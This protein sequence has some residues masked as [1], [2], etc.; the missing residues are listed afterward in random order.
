MDPEGDN[1]V[2]R[3]QGDLRAWG[4]EQAKLRQARSAALTAR[5]RLAAVQADRKAQALTTP[6]IR[7]SQ[8]SHRPVPEGALKKMVSELAAR[9]SIDPGRRNRLDGPRT[10]K[11]DLLR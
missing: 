1:P 4:I 8:P 5:Y 11:K 9:F 6:R 10:S 7:P 2:A 3:F